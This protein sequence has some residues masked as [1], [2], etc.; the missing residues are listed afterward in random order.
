MKAVIGGTVLHHPLSRSYSTAF[1]HP[2]FI[3]GGENNSP[4]LTHL[5]RNQSGRHRFIHRS[6]TSMCLLWLR[7]VKDTLSR[8]DQSE[9]CLEI[10]R[11]VQSRGQNSTCRVR[12]RQ[13]SSHLISEQISLCNE[14]S[15]QLPL[16]PLRRSFLKQRNRLGEGAC[17]SGKKRKKNKQRTRETQTYIFQ[18]KKIK[19]TTESVFRGW[20]KPVSPRREKKTNIL[21]LISYESFEACQVQQ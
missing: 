1:L 6:A 16:T 17:L 3:S 21:G 9:R 7:S 19:I 4:I 14:V 12:A 15:L 11:M 8:E 13:I 5:T 20:A 2:H 18:D 10:T